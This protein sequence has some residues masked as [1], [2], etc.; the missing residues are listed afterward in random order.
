MASLRKLK[1]DINYLMDEV[2][3]DSYLSL[4]FHPEH[5]DAIVN[6]IRDAVDLRNTL[7]DRANNPIEK[8]SSSLVRKHYAAVRRDMFEG[9]DRLFVRLSEVG[10]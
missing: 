5:K 9:I 8:K 6:V 7:Y 4:W 2:V 1:R 3:T 10:K